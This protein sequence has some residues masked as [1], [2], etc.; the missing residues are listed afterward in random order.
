M[1]QI[2]QIPC[3]N[4]E[5]PISQLW[6][7]QQFEQNSTRHWS[8]LG[9]IKICSYRFVELMNINKVRKTIF[10]RLRSD[11]D[12][13]STLWIWLGH[14]ATIYISLRLEGVYRQKGNLGSWNITNVLLITEMVQDGNWLV[15]CN[16]FRPC[17]PVAV[18]LLRDGCHH[19]S[20]LPLPTPSHQHN[21]VGACH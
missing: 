4:L 8:D 5:K 14:S 3:N 19:V 21:V 13:G 6:Q 12:P 1:Y 15:S 10:I 16:H 11:L 18:S 7:I 17:L 9:P 2:W 20:V